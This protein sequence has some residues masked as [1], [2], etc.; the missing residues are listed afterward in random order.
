MTLLEK[1]TYFKQSMEH[2]QSALAWIIKY[3]KTLR[4]ETAHKHR[5]QY[6]TY[7]REAKFHKQALRWYASLYYSYQ[8]KLVYSL[9]AREAICYVFGPYCSQAL[10]VSG[11]ETGGTY[12]VYAQNGQYL[13]LF[14]MGSNER[15]IYGH[16][17]VPYWQARFA[18]NY[19]AATNFNWS[20]WECKP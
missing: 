13:G 15:A 6:P 7:D 19:F 17:T 18:Y 2:D 8:Q 4:K 3:R 16:S 1:V 9:P 12:S 5:E 11:C 20:P 14:Q 10:S